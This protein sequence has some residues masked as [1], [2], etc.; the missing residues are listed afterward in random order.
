MTQQES[1][2][3]E[4]LKSQLREMFQL[5]RGDLDFGLYRIMNQKR[6]DVSQFL[7]E[8]LLPQVHE[9]LEECQ[10]SDSSNVEQELKETIINLQDAGVDPETAPK[11]K[12][13]R[14]KLSQCVDL[15]KLENEIYS[16][17]YNFFKRYYSEG[18]FMSLRRYKEGVYALPYEGEE[19]KLHW[20]NHDQYYIKTSENLKNYSFK[21]VNGKKHIRFEL[22]AGGTETNNNQA[23]NGKERRSILHEE[24]SGRAQFSCSFHKSRQTSYIKFARNFRFWFG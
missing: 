4:Q 13:L 12:K 23:A 18:D 24:S 3:F 6:D 22:V 21:T 5:D 15:K 11:V 17:L 20:A 14:A 7:D 9:I 8:Q 16:D 10:S 2:A 19:V 1:P